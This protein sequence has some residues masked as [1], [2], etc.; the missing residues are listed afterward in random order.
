MLSKALRRVIINRV[1]ISLFEFISIMKTR[2]KSSAHVDRPVKRI[3]FNRPQ[4]AVESAPEADASGASVAVRDVIK[5]GV[6]KETRSGKG[7]ARAR[8]NV[9]R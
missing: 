8:M 1:K 6:N 9:A 4:P 5:Y 2:N 3:E 7:G